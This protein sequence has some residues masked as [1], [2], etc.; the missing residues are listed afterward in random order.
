MN[1]LIILSS[2]TPDLSA[3]QFLIQMVYSSWDETRRTN[4]GGAPPH[5]NL[6]G[7]LSLDIDAEKK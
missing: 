4:A 5:A 6:P 1:A 2:V 3:H 7:Y